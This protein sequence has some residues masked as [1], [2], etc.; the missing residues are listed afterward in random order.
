MVNDFLAKLCEKSHFDESCVLASFEFAKKCD[1]EKLSFLLFEKQP[2]ILENG[3]VFFKDGFYPYKFFDFASNEIKKACLSSETGFLYLYI[4]L[5]EKSLEYFTSLGFDEDVFFDTFEGISRSCD[6]Y[7]KEN[8][9]D[10]I[11][12]YFWLSGHLRA[13]VIRLGVFE[14]Q[15]GIFGF[16]ETP[17]LMGRKIKKNDTAVFLHVPFGTDFSLSSRLSSYKKAFEVFGNKIL[18]CDSWLLYPANAE[19]LDN[20][21]NIR[22]FAEDFHVFHVDHD[23]CYEDLYRIFGKN[24]DFSDIEK[25]PSD[26]SLQRLYIERLKSG[27]PSG[28]AA[29]IRI[30]V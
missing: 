21:S 1:M 26:T 23:R 24:L 27:Q 19:G 12:D 18:V 7:R 30:L 10:G 20:D 3:T 25:L 16:D 8:G 17:S 2:E 9:K 6:A 4:A 14:Y 11:Y 29:G 28:S 22:S 13:N 15:N 5:A